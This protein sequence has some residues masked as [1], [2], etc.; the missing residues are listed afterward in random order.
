MNPQTEKF[1]NEFDIPSYEQWK[2]ACVKALKGADFDKKMLKRTYEGITLEGI[3]SKN[4]WDEIPHVQS[5]LPGFYPYIR[6]NKYSGSKKHSWLVVQNLP[7]SIPEEFNE[8]AKSEL[9]K[10]VQ[11]IE[12]NINQYYA[13][14][15]NLKENSDLNNLN[16]LISNYDNLKVAFENIDLENITLFLNSGN[17]TYPFFKMF[18]DYFDDKE[19][20]TQNLQIFYGFDLISE[21]AIN[22]RTYTNAKD[23]FEQIAEV[24]R[25]NK[26]NSPNSKSIKINGEV[27]HNSGANSVQE[28][29]YSISEA[30]AYIRE[31]SQLGL[32][33]DDIANQ[34]YLSIGIGNQYF[35]ELAKIR[36]T[37]LIWAK[38]I[39][40]FGGSEES[41]KLFISASTS[42]RELTK[43]DAYVNLL[44]NTTQAFSAAAGGADSIKVSFFDSLWGLPVEFSRR[45]SRN[46]QLILKEEAHLLDTIDPVG[47]SWYIEKIT[48]QLAEKIWEEIQNIESKGG[49]NKAFRENYIQEKITANLS[50][51]LKNLSTRKDTLLGTN[52]YP[53]LDEK[54]ILNVRKYHQS[55]IKSYLERQSENNSLK[56]SDIYKDY[57]IKNFETEE[58]KPLEENRVSEIFENLR[59]NA[60]AYKEENG[61][62]PTIDLICFAPLKVYKPRADFSSDFFAVGGFKSNVIDGNSSGAEALEKI[63]TKEVQCGVICSSDAVY[64]EVVV[65][66]ARAFKEKYPNAILILAGYPKDKVEDYKESGVDEFIHVKA[67]IYKTNLDLQMHYEI[68][69]KEIN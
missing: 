65:D 8:I 21:L 9:S 62:M 24:I 7:Y 46:T 56:I 13:L 30:I 31:L 14:N 68:I 17:L 4:V 29:A 58:V 34:I 40:E 16:L 35:T 15:D 64:E 43:Y 25:W 49:I 19:I 36:A 20:N 10:G 66:F 18:L 52:K 38:I 27:Y 32:D 57:Q 54:P 61:E 42:K 59:E 63:S 1:F 47:G 39:K 22:G 26:E 2:D 53:N 28:I 3:Y 55:E 60:L 5:D 69:K 51:R 45:M 23:K 37:R 41:Q 67:D 11:A 33:I 12:L 48:H 44:R 6:G 50:Q